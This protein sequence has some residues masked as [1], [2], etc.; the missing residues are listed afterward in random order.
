MLNEV[1]AGCRFTATLLNL[2]SSTMLSNAIFNAKYRRAKLLFSGWA[3]LSNEQNKHE[4][5]M[6]ANVM[7]VLR[8][9]DGA[10]IN[11]QIK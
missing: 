10:L 5:T 9:P 1:K 4:M 11:N 2:I 3:L 7:K 6:Q 8:R